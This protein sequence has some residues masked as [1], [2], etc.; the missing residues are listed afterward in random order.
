MH[1]HT[2][3]QTHTHLYTYYTCSHAHTHTHTHTLTHTETHMYSQKQSHQKS[4]SYTHTY[5]HTETHTIQTYFQSS[6]HAHRYTPFQGLNV[7]P[8]L[9]INWISAKLV[10]S[11]NTRQQEHQLS[12]ELNEHLPTWRG[13]LNMSIL[14]FVVYLSNC[15]QQTDGNLSTLGPLELVIRQ[16]DDHI[17]NLMK[18]GR[19]KSI[20]SGLTWIPTSHKQLEICQIGWCQQMT[21]R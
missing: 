16:R 19:W 5:K 3:T 18:S 21:S 8:L 17:P 13:H 6:T 11:A 20:K 2:H 14:L 12:M 4:H 9:T 15:C 7:Y 1:T 10:V